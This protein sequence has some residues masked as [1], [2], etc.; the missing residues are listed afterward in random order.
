[1]SKTEIKHYKAGASRT[2]AQIAEEARALVTKAV[3]EGV[4]ADSIV[5]ALRVCLAS[6]PKLQGCSA[7]SIFAA[8]YQIAALG[9]TPGDSRGLAYLIP[10]GS[11]CQLIVGYRGLIQLAVGSGGATSIRAGVVGKDDEWEWVEGLEPV[12]RHKPKSSAPRPADVI[13]AYAIAELPGGG[14]SW[15]VLTR[16]DL[17][18]RRKVGASGKGR[19]SPWD[20]FYSEMARKSAVRALCKYL[21]L[22]PD[23]AARL[24]RAEAAEA[25][26]LDERGTQ[27][28]ADLGYSVDVE[29]V[30]P[31]E[32]AAP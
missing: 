24:T 23:R 10:Y 1:M 28:L 22:S 21:I 20:E 16:D 11:T 32:E 2:P 8:V 18:A 19:A 25:G 12:L 14:R 9:L 13:A 30:E 26:E 3:P 15:V 17:E 31:A 7:A 4:K 27:L 5:L 6:T 29:A